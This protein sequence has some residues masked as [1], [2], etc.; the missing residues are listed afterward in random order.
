MTGFSELTRDLR[1]QPITK[2]ESKRGMTVIE[3]HIS[4]CIQDIFPGKREKEYL[5]PL[6]NDQEKERLFE[7]L[8]DAINQ[9]FTGRR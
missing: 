3:T 5:V 4:I 9:F 2:R 7:S 6:M 1:D 8:D